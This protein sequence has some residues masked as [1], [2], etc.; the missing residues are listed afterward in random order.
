MRIRKFWMP[1]LNSRMFV[2]AL[3]CFPFQMAGGKPET[4][5][6]TIPEG[7]RDPKFRERMASEPVRRA[8]LAW[9]VQGAIDY[10]DHGLGKQPEIVRKATANLRADMDDVLAQPHVGA[11]SAL[12][13][14]QEGDERDRTIRTVGKLLAA[15]RDPDDD[16]S[17]RLLATLDELGPEPETPVMVLPTTA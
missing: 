3:H 15:L 14:T 13:R 10:E 16:D 1:F 2:Q 4:R 8:V 6:S 5:T 12:L 9:A 7:K 17:K 11:L